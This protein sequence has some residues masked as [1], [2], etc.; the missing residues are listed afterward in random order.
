MHKR[1]RRFERLVKY[2][3]EVR[4][5]KCSNCG[6]RCSGNIYAYPSLKLILEKEVSRY[7]TKIN[8]VQN[9]LCFTCV[10]G[11]SQQYVVEKIKYDNFL[12]SLDWK[13]SIMLWHQLT[14]RIRQNEM[15]KR[16]V[17]VT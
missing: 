3:N 7:Y 14:R 10:S 6:R 11:Y 17:Q 9:T 8:F 5:M 13:K 2:Y 16:T 1:T 15:A 12:T 4:W